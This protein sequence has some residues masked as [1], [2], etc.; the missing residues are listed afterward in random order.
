MY[1]RRPASTIPQIDPH[2]S[3]SFLPP[4]TD[5][6]AEA[7][8]WSRCGRAVERWLGY[9]LKRLL[10]PIHMEHRIKEECVSVW[11]VAPSAAQQ[12]MACA[13]CHVREARTPPPP[14]TSAA[15]PT[16]ARRLT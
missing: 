2:P 3:Y 7:V 6:T 12:A 13:H 8:S 1:D 4:S 10:N 9:R 14:R 5:I 15:L 11:G 16:R